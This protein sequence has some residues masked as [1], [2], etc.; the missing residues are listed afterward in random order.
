MHSVI[1]IVRIII[2]EIRFMFLRISGAT[3]ISHGMCTSRLNNEWSVSKGSILE[4]GNHFSSLD[5]CRILVRGGKLIIGKDVG[6][7]SN[8]IVA[9][10]SKIEIC[11]GV[12]IGPNVCI[13]DHDHDFRCRGG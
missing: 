9:C 5:R 4:I 1:S 13:Y 8:C 3:V 12:E 11:D 7:N 6:L 2:N 10:H